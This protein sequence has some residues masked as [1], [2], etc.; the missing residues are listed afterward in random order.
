M[1]TARDIE[2]I[3]ERYFSNTEKIIQ[4][5]EGETLLLHDQENKTV[6]LILKGVLH[7]YLL[8]PNMREEAA[9][10]AAKGQF[11]GIYSYFSPN[12]TSYSTVKAATDATIAY[13]DIPFEKHSD[14][15]T[16]EMQ[17]L[18]FPH[19]VDELFFRQKYARKITIQHQKEQ[20]RLT[21][22][23]KMAT[24]GQLAAGLAHELNNSI[25]VIDSNLQRFVDFAEELIKETRKKRFHPYFQKGLE[26]G[27]V[28]SS[29][30]ARKAR[31]DYE[32]Y[33]KSKP[34]LIQ[35]LSRSGIKAVELVELEKERSGSAL[36]AY[37]IWESGSL[38]H[39]TKI[40]AQHSKHV[41]KSVK[42]LGVANHHWSSDVDINQSLNESLT[43]LKSYSKGISLKLKLSRIPNIYACRGELTQVW[44][45]LVKNG[46]ESLRS[47]KVTNPELK[48]ETL[49][50]GPTIEVK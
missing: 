26:E 37:Q 13:Y 1:K 33:F 46:I 38:L 29:K 48:I 15:E 21:K 40:A 2:S 43:I 28:L 49:E 45:N 4:L 35:K 16:E 42:Q 50:K 12:G 17:R 3:K 18:F 22:S 6:F 44:I 47:A 39:D 41:V 20:E 24:L 31:A 8:E 9:F 25:A 30:E 5:K 27:Q 14:K 19:I 10:E 23:E 11:I 32:K 7:G 34:H 36:E